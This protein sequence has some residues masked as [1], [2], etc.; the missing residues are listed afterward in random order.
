MKTGECVMKTLITAL[1]V[2]LATS[3]VAKTQRTKAARIQ[4]YNSGTQPYNSGTQ[5]N[6]AFCQFHYAHTDPDPRIRLQILRDCRFWE[7]PGDGR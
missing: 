6:N 1:A 2:I 3:A 4:P 7:S 5:V